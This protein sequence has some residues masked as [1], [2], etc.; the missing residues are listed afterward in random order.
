MPK[1]TLDLTLRES[2]VLRQVL[3]GLR[4]YSKERNDTILKVI[5]QINGDEQTEAE[6][7]YNEGR[8]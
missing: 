7:V 2:I 5:R 1:I 6:K 3:M 4:T 8:M